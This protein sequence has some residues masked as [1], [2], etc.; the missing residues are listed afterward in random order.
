MIVTASV[1]SMMFTLI[2]SI[3]RREVAVPLTSQLGGSPP[4]AVSLLENVSRLG[5]R[6]SLNTMLDR[7]V[8]WAADIME[9]HKAF[10]LLPYFRSTDSSTSWLTAFGAWMDAACLVTSVDPQGHH[11]EARLLHQIGCRLLQDLADRFKLGKSTVLP[12]KDVEFREIYRRLSGSG[13]CSESVDTARSNFIALRSAYYPS[14]KALCAQFD[15]PECSLLP[16]TGALNALKS[17]TNV[18]SEPILATSTTEIFA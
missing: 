17:A 4:C 15:M 7:R 18:P 12:M 6:Q 16:Q 5:G 1:V 3:Q 9:T 14:Y 13:Y 10:P 11:F 2:G 8:S